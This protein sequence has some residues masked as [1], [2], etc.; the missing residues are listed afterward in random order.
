MLA[1][2]AIHTG[3]ACRC[4]FSAKGEYLVCIRAEFNMI[5]SDHALH[6]AMLIGPVEGTGEDVALLHDL[7]RLQRASRPIGV[8]CIDGPVAR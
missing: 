7:N 4:N 8:I 3:H 6:L 2:E 5:A 1:V